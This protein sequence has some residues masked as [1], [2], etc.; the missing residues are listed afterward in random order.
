MLHDV[1]KD[2]NS[3]T[4]TKSVLD[5]L[6]SQLSGCGCTLL[7]KKRGHFGNVIRFYFHDEFLFDA[8]PARDWIKFYFSAR[9]SRLAPFHWPRVKQNFPDAE[10]RPKDLVVSIRLRDQETVSRFCAFLG[11]GLGS[12]I[13]P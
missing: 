8:L 2:R 3:S 7:V 12:V 11:A 6:M 4:N 5:T 1:F 10:Q 13:E 9:A